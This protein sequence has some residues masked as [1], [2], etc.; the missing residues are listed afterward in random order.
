MLIFP[1]KLMLVPF[2]ILFYAHIT[3]WPHPP[4]MSGNISIRPPPPAHLF[5]WYNIRMIPTKDSDQQSQSR[6]L[7]LRLSDLGWEQVPSNIADWTQVASIDLTSNPLECDCKLLWLKDLLS[8]IEAMHSVR[9]LIYI[10]FKNRGLK[11]L[12]EGFPWA[13]W[14][15]DWPHFQPIGVW[16]QTSVAQGPSVLDRGHAQCKNLDIYSFQK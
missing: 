3:I 10:H 9:I 1:K 2:F 16:L 13:S 5:W 15:L 8:S 4:T 6:Q 12:L 7:R 14:A 11:R